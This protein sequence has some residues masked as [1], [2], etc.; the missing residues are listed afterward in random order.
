M[1]GP[2][3]LASLEENWKSQFKLD[4]IM[5]GEEAVLT[6]EDFCHNQR[7]NVQRSSQVK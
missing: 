6:D 1:I 7:G 3:Q 5:T 2:S 4:E